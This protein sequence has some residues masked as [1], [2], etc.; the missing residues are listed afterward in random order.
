MADER[1]TR[2]LFLGEGASGSQNLYVNIGPAH[3]AMHGIVRIFAELDG[4]TVLKIDVEIGQGRET[5]SATG[6]PIGARATMAPI[7]FSLDR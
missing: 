6:A 7:R 3:S 4:E 5:R 2:E 1:V